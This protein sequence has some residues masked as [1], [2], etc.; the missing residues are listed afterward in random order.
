MK[1]FFGSILTKAGIANTLDQNAH[2]G[3][4]STAETNPVRRGSRE[5]WPTDA[6]KADFHSLVT[7][8][9]REHIISCANKLYGNFPPIKGAVDSKATYAVGR[10]WNPVSK[11]TDKAWAMKAQSLLR[12][13]W[14]P[15]ADV[16]GTDFTSQ[17][18]VGSVSVDRDG[19]FGILLAKT[20]DGWP[21]VQFVPSSRIGSGQSQP[22]IL[23]GPFRGLRS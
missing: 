8:F 7:E 11:S 17:L 4:I 6:A 15:S 3:L 23:T 9:D 20:A 22:E 14:Y 2:F 18:Y 21:Q 16:T 10:A 1:Q 13:I 5:Y 19:G 12:T